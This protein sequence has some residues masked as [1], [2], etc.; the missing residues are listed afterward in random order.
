[1]LFI[2]KSLFLWAMKNGELLKYHRVYKYTE[3]GNVIE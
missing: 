1:M 2:G 3:I